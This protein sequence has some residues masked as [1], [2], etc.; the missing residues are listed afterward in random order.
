MEVQFLPPTTEYARNYN[1]AA[2][3][4]LLARKADEFEN[5]AVVMTG[6]ASGDWRRFSNMWASFLAANLADAHPYIR[7]GIGLL[8]WEIGVAAMAKIN[9]SGGE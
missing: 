5:A 7:T 1:R 8:L 4:V 2:A 3:S 9:R 6:A